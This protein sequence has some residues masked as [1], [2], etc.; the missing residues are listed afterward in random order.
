[1]RNPLFCNV[2]QQL[3]VIQEASEDLTVVSEK[4]VCKMCAQHACSEVIKLTQLDITCCPC[5]MGIMCHDLEQ[6]ATQLFHLLCT[7][8]GILFDE[9]NPLEAKS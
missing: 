8:E 7:H 4:F 5:S 2:L 6:I 1:M 3:A 9:R